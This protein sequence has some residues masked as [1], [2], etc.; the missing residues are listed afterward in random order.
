MNADELQETR[1]STA[2]DQSLWDRLRELVPDDK[3]SDFYG[4]MAYTRVLS[5]DDEILRIIDAMGLLTLLTCEAPSRIAQERLLTK[6]LLDAYLRD[7]E[8]LSERMHQYVANIE[9]KLVALPNE[10]RVA[11]DTTRLAKL[12]EESTRQVFVASGLPEAALGWKAAERRMTRALQAIDTLFKELTDPVRGILPRVTTAGEENVGKI[13]RAVQL[14]SG[15]VKRFWLPVIAVAS[16]VIGIVAGASARFWWDHRD[17]VVPAPMSID[18]SGPSIP[19]QTSTDDKSI[20][21]AQ[22]KH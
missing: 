1:L 18:Y 11:L 12:L 14:L 8:Q 5:P 16:I 2:A 13:N 17:S 22:K 7:A 10:V 21:N 19:L 9:A 20:H 15:D 6:E 4:V 3:L